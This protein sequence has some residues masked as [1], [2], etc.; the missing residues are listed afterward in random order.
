MKDFLVAMVVFRNASQEEIVQAA[1]S[2]SPPLGDPLED[3]EGRET[4]LIRFYFDLFDLN[5]EGAIGLEEL[6]LVLRCFCSRG[7][8]GERSL[9]P[10]PPSEEDIESMF[11]AMS[12]DSTDSITF[13]EFQLFYQTLLASS[14]KSIQGQATGGG[15]ASN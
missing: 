6:K 7:N 1:S 15:A 3:R 10:R 12:R 14:H 13:T 8:G 4:D 5:H 2:A 9:D 11:R